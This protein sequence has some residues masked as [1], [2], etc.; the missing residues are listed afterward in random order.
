MGAGQRLA[1]SALEGREG[2]VGILAQVDPGDGQVVRLDRS[3][4]AGRL[5][6]DELAEGVRPTWDGPVM[7]MVGRELE[8]PADGR[9]ALVELAR[10]MQ[11]ARP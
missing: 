8:E 4:V 7:R 5:R 9:P 11:E 3:E 1:Q 6:V 10:R 2:R